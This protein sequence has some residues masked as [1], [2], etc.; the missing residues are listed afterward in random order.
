[1]CLEVGWCVAGTGVDPSHP[2]QSANSAFQGC[3]GDIAWAQ[4]HGPSKG[5]PTKYCSAPLLHVLFLVL[6]QEE[7]GTFSPGGTEGWEAPA[8]EL[9]CYGTISRSLPLSGPWFLHLCSKEVGIHVPKRFP[10]PTC[11]VGLSLDPQAC[12]SIQPEAPDVCP[13]NPC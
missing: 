7:M 1:M 6:E 12:V 5:S 2:T 11:H 4:T 8:L 3:S 10:S 9:I 13:P